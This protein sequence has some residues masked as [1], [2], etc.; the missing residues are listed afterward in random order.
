MVE[1]SKSGQAFLDI[2]DKIGE[3]PLPPYIKDHSSPAERYQ[4]VYNSSE[5]S[6]SVAAPTAGLHFTPELLEALQKK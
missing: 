5:K 6:G 1:F 2:V 3:V 4:T